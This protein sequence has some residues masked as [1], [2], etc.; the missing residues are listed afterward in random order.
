LQDEEKRVKFIETLAKKGE[1]YGRQLLIDWYP[2]V[3]RD[4]IDWILDMKL[5]Q[6]S[7]LSKRVQH[8]EGLR[9]RKAEI[10]KE[11]QNIKGIIVKE[12]KG[13]NSKYSYP[14]KTEIT[15]LDYEFEKETPV[16]VKAAPE[17]TLVLVNDKFIKKIRRSRL[18][19]NQVGIHCLSDDVISF[20]DSKGRLL[21]VDLDKIGF[22]SEKDRGIYLPVYLQEADDFEVVAHELITDKKV[23]Y[24][25]SDGFASVVDYGEWNESKRTTRV[26][27]KGVPDVSNLIIGEVDFSKSFIVLFTELGRFGFVSADFKHKHRTARTKLI[28]VKQGDKVTKAYSISYTDMLKVVSNPEKY[29]D[30]LSYLTG[31]DVFNSEYLNSIL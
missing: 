14:R 9:A 24:V 26:T 10:E 23:G 28:P 21:R 15:D 2:N 17:P 13:L 11:L 31:G 19:D 4:T 3:D 29:L 20:I 18:N 8:L 16:V 5:R 27:Q 7:G 25:Y 1:A 22:M 30:K 6:F 12:L